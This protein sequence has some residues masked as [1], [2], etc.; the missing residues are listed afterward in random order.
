M[1]GAFID[2]LCWALAQLKI[3]IHFHPYC[4]F[5]MQALLFPFCW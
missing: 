5:V 4:T 2:Y 3:I 1:A